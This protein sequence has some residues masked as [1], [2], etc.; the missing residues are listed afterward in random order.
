MWIAIA[1][2][3][4]TWLVP[5]WVHY[6][7]SRD[8]DYPITFPHRWAFLFDTWQGEYYSGL[9]IYK[10]DYQRLAA[11]DGVILIVATGLLVSFRKP[12]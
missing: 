4:T 2:L 9:L 8:Y 12:N 6:P 3:V 5:P 11:M 7:G 1:L 10:I